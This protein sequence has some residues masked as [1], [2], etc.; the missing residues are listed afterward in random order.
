[1]TN[2]TDLKKEQKLTPLLRLGFRPFFLFAGIFAFV[3]M[4]LWLLSLRAIITIEPLNGIF[5]WHSHE[6]LFGFVPAV[7]SGFLLTAVQNWTG[8]PSVKGYKLLFLV[9]LWASARILIVLN[10]DIPLWLLMSIDLAFLPTV[11]LFLAIPLIQVNQYRNMIFLPLLCLMTLA[12]FFT[13]LP[14]FNF[15]VSFNLQGLHSMVILTTLL[16]ALLGGR[17]IPMFTANGTNTSKILPL[18]WLEI[19]ALTSLFLIFVFFIAGLTKYN[20]VLGLLCAVSALLHFYRIMRWRPWL[21][22][23]VPL[24]WVLHFTIMFIPIGLSL[25]ALHFLFDLVAFSTALHSLTVGAIGGM[26]LA[27][28][29]RVSLGHSGRPLTVPPIMVF[30]FLSIIIAAL[31]RSLAVAFLPLYTAELWLFS[32]L[33]WCS[34]F[35]CFVW[36]YLPI[37]GR[38]RIDGRP[39]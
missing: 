34:A 17:V 26:I 1:M 29:S 2:T 11:G 20:L 5:W 3:S 9:V 32:G 38:Q 39:G 21:T 25:M 4:A 6:M 37:L 36:V 10:I 31:L 28:M 22:V 23:K 33:F 12:N 24:V 8:I 19:L 14:Q 7:I 15:D 27:M 18:K 30:A 16:I 13:Y 35:A